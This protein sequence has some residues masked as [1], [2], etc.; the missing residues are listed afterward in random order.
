MGMRVEEAGRMGGLSLLRKRGRH[1]FAGIGKKGQ[2]AMRLKYPD[3]GREWG[4]AGGRPRKSKLLELR[5]EAVHHQ[6]KEVGPAHP[7]RA[8]SLVIIALKPD[9]ATNNE[10]PPT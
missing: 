1:Y 9:A 4:R 7:D 6:R 10:E 8:S 5:E 2:A 3:M